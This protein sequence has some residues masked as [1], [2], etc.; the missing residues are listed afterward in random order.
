MKFR[1]YPNHISIK[2]AGVSSHG[3]NVESACW[4]VAVLRVRRKKDCSRVSAVQ[5]SQTMKQFPTWSLVILFIAAV[6]PRGLADEEPVG[7]IWKRVDDRGSESAK[8]FKVV[9]DNLYAVGTGGVIWKT[10]DR[11]NWSVEK[12]EISE[13]LNNLTIGND[14]LIAVGEAGR[15]LKQESDGTWAARATN[16]DTGL[17][18]VTFGGGVFVTVGNDGTILSSLDGDI[19]NPRMS[20]TTLDLKDVLWDGE[21]FLVVGREKLIATSANGE[22]WTIH[23]QPQAYPR[24][25]DFEQIQYFNGEYMINGSFYSGDGI[26]F[27]FTSTPKPFIATKLAEG[28]GVNVGLGPDGKIGVSEDGRN[29]NTVTIPSKEDLIAIQWTGEKFLAMTAARTF[30][31]SADGRRWT[32]RGLSH[33]RGALG[34]G[35][36]TGSQYLVVGPW[37]PNPRVENSLGGGANFFL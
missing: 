6:I 14:S 13:D 2:I 10:A 30:F 11:I 36:W 29:W 22:N 28:D 25:F 4:M 8:A 37:I 35:V 21:R 27:T 17:N 16:I 24:S 18:A 7:R 12:T 15:I 5:L 26:N 9:G 31:E 23:P 1:A 32:G 3:D 33:N 20:G 34:D 19:W